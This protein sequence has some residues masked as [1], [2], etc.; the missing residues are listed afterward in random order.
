MGIG[1]GIGQRSEADGNRVHPKAA[2]DRSGH[3]VQPMAARDELIAK[4][5]PDVRSEQVLAGALP[6]A[7]SSESCS[8]IGLSSLRRVPSS[9]RRLLILAQLRPSVERGGDS[10]TLRTIVKLVRA[11]RIRPADLLDGIR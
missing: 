10:S 6:R 4:G 8:V 9:G 1:F 5:R 7:G 2:L 11:L 3:R